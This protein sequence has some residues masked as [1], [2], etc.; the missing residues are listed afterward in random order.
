MGEID[1]GMREKL[2]SDLWF[3]Q[4]PIPHR[5]RPKRKIDLQGWGSE[6]FF[7]T[8]SVRMARPK[9]IVEIGVWKGFSTIT[10]GR[11]M[12]NNNIDGV[13]IAVDT[14][15]GSWDHW[16]NEKWFNELYDKEIKGSIYDKF[17]ANVV[18]SGM[19]EYVVPL[20]L[21]STNAAKLLEKRNIKA[22]LIHIDAGHDYVSVKNDISIWWPRLNEGG[23]MVG[24]DYHIDGKWPEVRIAFDEFIKENELEYEISAPKIRIFKR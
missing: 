5:S 24:D 4:D 23:I 7:I 9:I 14:W 15:L 17:K 18:L 20:P 11:T 3:G 22:E 12:K 2:I 16:I 8:D 13:V 6:H 1:M 19:R 21:D 10:M